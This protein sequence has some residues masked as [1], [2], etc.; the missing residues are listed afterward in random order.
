MA[1]CVWAVLCE[2]VIIDSES[3]NLS[4][5]STI[6]RV[7]ISDPPPAVTEETAI[8]IPSRLALMWTRSEID[9]PEGGL[10][11]IQYVHPDGKKGTSGVIPVDLNANANFRINAAMDKFPVTIPG[12]YWICVQYAASAK[13]P[14]WKTV[15]RIPL[16]VTFPIAEA[17][18]PQKSAVKPVRRKPRAI[19]PEARR[20]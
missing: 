3:M 1:E 4:M 2:R 16:D 10:S 20:S 12:R 13:K 5:I 18:P 14:T 8:S 15:S 6:E 9:V 11:R 19:K 17:E 7:S